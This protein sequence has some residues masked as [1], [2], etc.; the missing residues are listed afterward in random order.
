VEGFGFAQPSKRQADMQYKLLTARCESEKRIVAIAER[1]AF[2]R[3]LNIT[4]I[5]KKLELSAN[6]PDEYKTND[7]GH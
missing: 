1:G 5:Y 2:R 4:E 7:E 6:V 3:A